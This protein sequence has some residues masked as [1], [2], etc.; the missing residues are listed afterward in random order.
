M[1]KDK[2]WK[3]ETKNTY[4]FYVNGIISVPVFCPCID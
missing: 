3:N 4:M 1:Q 2:E